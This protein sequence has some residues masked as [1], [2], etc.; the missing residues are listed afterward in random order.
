MNHS[1]NAAAELPAIY[2]SAKA[3]DLSATHTMVIASIYM[4]GEGDVQVGAG[5]MSQIL[6]FQNSIILDDSKLNFQSELNDME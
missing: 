1:R 5:R 4:S 2:A 6:G 3:V